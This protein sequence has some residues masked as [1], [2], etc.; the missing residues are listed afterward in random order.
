MTKFGRLRI[1]VLIL[2]YDLF[3]L[4]FVV[5]QSSKILTRSNNLFGGYCSF[6][7]WRRQKNER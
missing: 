2:V 3:N 4:N 7:L 5:S 6:F 1:L